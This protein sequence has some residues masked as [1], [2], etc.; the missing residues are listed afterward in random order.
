MLGRTGISTRSAARTG[1]SAAW[2]AC[3]AV[4]STKISKPSASWFSQRRPSDTQRAISVGIIAKRGKFLHENMRSLVRQFLDERQIQNSNDE[5]AK[6]GK[7][8]LADDLCHLQDSMARTLT[9]I[10]GKPIQERG[11]NVGDGTNTCLSARASGWTKE[12]REDSAA[13]RRDC[14]VLW[15]RRYQGHQAHCRHRAGRGCCPHGPSALVLR[16]DRYSQ[17]C[18]CCGRGTRV[19]RGG[20]SQV[21]RDDGQ[22]HRL[23]TRGGHR[24]RRVYL[25][26]LPVLGRAGPLDGQ[27]PTVMATPKLSHGTGLGRWLIQ[28]S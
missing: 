8:E 24:L 20:R 17:R 16:G 28:R 2:S 7:T 13:T 23:S 21:G 15:P 4:S 25:P 11:S 10:L 19:H 27:A 1:R 3:G 14:R 5:S 12:P 6:A 18:W 22:N 26:R 9:A